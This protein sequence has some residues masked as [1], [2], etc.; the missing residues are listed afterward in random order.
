MA[1]ALFK[2]MSYKDEYEVGR[3]H[4]ETP[5]LA[6]LQTVFEGHFKVNYHL[7]PPLLPLGKDGRGRPRK[8]RFGPWMQR[9]LRLLARLKWVRATWMDPFGYTAE[10][11]MERGLIAWYE[12]I[13]AKI[14][15][16]LPQQNPEALIRLARAPMEIRGFG[17]VKHAAVERVK[18]E[19]AIM[20][21]G[22][23]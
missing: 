2:L 3:L 22:L 14:I 21:E 18:Q 16:T 9:P 20:L 1:R 11:Q 15:A 8:R 23:Q 12:E 7:A 4:T 17:P 13:V 10:R 19:V 5:F 6:E